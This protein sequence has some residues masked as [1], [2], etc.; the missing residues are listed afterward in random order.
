M[1]FIADPYICVVICP[2]QFLLKR[3][4]QASGKS[5]FVYD[6]PKKLTRNAL[7][8]FE[9]LRRLITPGSVPCLSSKAIK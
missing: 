7:I 3:N 9:L 8:A 5:S 4:N 6:F 1:R 2:I